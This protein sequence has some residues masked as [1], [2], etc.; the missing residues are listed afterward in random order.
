MK[1]VAILSIPGIT[2]DVIGMTSPPPFT[3]PAN[4]QKLHPRSLFAGPAANS[5]A[6]R[7]IPSDSAPAFPLAFARAAPETQLP[8][9]SKLFSHGLPTRAEGEGSKLYDPVD[10]FLFGPAKIA[11]RDNSKPDSCASSFIIVRK[12]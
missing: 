7:H 5:V 6:A 1:R 9:L 12:K 4:Q 11:K 10:S 2:P 8:A 3:V